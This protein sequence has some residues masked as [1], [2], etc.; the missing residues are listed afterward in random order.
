MR[1]IGRHV[2]AGLVAGAVGT[3]AM[4]AVLYRR[5]RRGGGTDGAW[6]WESAT[7]VVGWDGASAPGK[8]GQKVERVVI[9]GEP[10]DA[11]A[12]PTT[13][14]VHWATGVG[15]AVPYALVA[16]ATSAHPWARAVALGPAV[17]LSGYVVLPLAKVYDPIW[18][19]DARTLGEDLS[20]HLVYG[21]VTSTVFALLTRSGHD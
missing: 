13:N 7:A 6:E 14:L 2:V 12:R 8:V 16:S 5:Y 1:A 3:A 17:W 9:G 21:S 15:W 4:D 19:Y 20:A 11:W 18:T 10:P